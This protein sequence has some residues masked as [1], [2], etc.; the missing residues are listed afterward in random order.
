[1]KNFRVLGVAAALFVLSL[2][3][4]FTAQAQ[5]TSGKGTLNDINFLE[6]RW[7]G[8]FN[9]GPI[10]ASWT[11][12]AG[13]NI[14]GFIRMM[15]DG[16]ATLYEIF[17]FE[18]TE[19]GPVAMVKHFRPGLISVEEKEQSD[20][21]KFIE[22]KKNQALF[23]LEGGQTRIIY[24]KRGDNQLVIQR[25]KQEGGK[26]SFVDLFVFNRIK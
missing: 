9:G 17:A 3:T 11:A 16:K 1:M 22:A 5:S 26:W 19:N 13:D 6:G 12:P 10:H 21:Y 7:E 8:T 14:A 15:K 2:L 24:E 4:G 18:Q 25:G 23:E 20:R